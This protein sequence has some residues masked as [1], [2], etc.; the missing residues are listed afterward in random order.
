MTSA[1]RTR[2]HLG[3]AALLLTATVS[4]TACGG[5][6]GSNPTA[7]SAPTTAPISAPTTAPT[8]DPTSAATSDATDSG[9][10]RSGTL[11][12]VDAYDISY[13]VPKGWIS[14]DGKDLL[15]PDNPV[16]KEVAEHMGVSV[17]RL[18]SSI[19]T[20]IQ[21]Y[22]VSDEGANAGLV[23][24]V[25]ALGVPASGV[26]AAQLKVQ[27]AGIGAKPGK[28]VHATT[29]AGHLTRL[30]YRWTTNGITINGVSMAVDLGTSTVQVTVSAHDAATAASIADLVQSSL[31][32]L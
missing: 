25:N 7:D 29:P 14:V 10:P 15:K 24:N 27:L 20:H 8:S 4:L 6:D 31:R 32:P 19:G 18:I 12:R 1:S 2:P 22:S 3:L 17:D 5:G 21:A 16:L 11:V 26:T 30:S 28:V 9:Q 23:D 13:R